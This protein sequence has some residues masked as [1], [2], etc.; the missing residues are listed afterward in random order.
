MVRVDVTSHKDEYLDALKQAEA[1]ALEIIGLRAERHAKE[2]LT[3]NK[4][5]DTGRLRNSITHATSEN[6]GADAYAD[7][8]G[9]QFSG[10]SANGTPKEGEVY[11]GTNVEY[12]PYVELGTSKQKAKP[13]LAPAIQ[14]HIEEYKQILKSTLGK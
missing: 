5:V 8:H 9:Q 14:R 13:Y 3:R 6:K 4:S 11:I 1:R 2:N 7:N 10:G 12:A